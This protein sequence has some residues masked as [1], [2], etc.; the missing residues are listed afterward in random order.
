VVLNFLFIPTYS[1][2]AA[3]WI[4]AITELL[5]SLLSV[6]TVFRH[7]KYFPKIGPLVKAIPAGI[8][9]SLLLFFLANWPIYIQIVAG[10]SLFVLLSYLFGALTR[11]DIK[12]ITGAN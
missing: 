7:Y 11:E 5:V 2:I 1:Y 12:R 4:S 8:A 3:A 9:M 6:I 10:G